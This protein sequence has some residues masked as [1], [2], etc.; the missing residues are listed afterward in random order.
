MKGFSVHSDGITGQDVTIVDED[1]NKV[2]RVIEAYIS[3]APNEVNTMHMTIV[4]DK[5]NV[6]CVGN[7]VT[8]M[9]PFCESLH[10][11]ECQEEPATFGQLAQTSTKL[12][13]R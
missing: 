13:K 1:G 4:V 3:L 8:L 6:Q 2:E 9:C 7:E 12:R 10:T 11:H 5:I